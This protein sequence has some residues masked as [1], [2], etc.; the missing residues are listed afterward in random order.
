MNGFYCEIHKNG[1][2]FH[3]TQNEL[4]LSESTIY[5]EENMLGKVWDG[6]KWNDHEPVEPVTNEY[7]QYY[8]TVNAALLGGE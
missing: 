4:P 1:F 6:E 5:A 8:E 2:C 7:Q 3:T